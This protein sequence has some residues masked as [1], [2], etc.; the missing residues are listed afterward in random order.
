MYTFHT[1]IFRKREEF[2]VH[3]TSLKTNIKESFLPIRNDRQPCYNY[4]NDVAIPVV[5]M[6]VVYVAGGHAV[7]PVALAAAS[8]IEVVCSGSADDCNFHLRFF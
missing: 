6:E 3:Y 7:A 1:E 2:R 8:R 5:G 4:H